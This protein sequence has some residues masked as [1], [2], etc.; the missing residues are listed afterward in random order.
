MMVESG[1][2]VVLIVDDEH[3]DDKGEPALL[4][5]SNSYSKIN[6]M[7]VWKQ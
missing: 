5:F 3:E 4:L 2:D 7:F 6:R 1:Q